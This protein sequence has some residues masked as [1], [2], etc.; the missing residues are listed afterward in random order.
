MRRDGREET[1]HRNIANC[2]VLS[3]FASMAIRLG[4]KSMEGCASSPE[5]VQIGIFYLL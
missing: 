1:R 4:I 2:N 3:G 5:M